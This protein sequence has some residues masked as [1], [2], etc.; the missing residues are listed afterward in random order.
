[1]VRYTYDTIVATGIFTHACT[2][3]RKRITTDQTWVKCKIYFT[4]ADR[5]RTKNLTSEEATYTTNQVETMVRDQLEQ[6]VAS[7]EAFQANKLPR[8]Q[9]LQWYLRR[10]LQII[11]QLTTYETSFKNYL[12]TTGTGMIIVIIATITTT[13]TTATTA[14][15]MIMATTTVTM[16]SYQLSK[17]MTRMAKSRFLLLHPWRHQKSSPS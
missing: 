9:Q 14:T 5:D 11:S 10:T 6:L 16:A 13:A 7:A 3:W 2:K 15:T 8:L 17:D 1:M 12:P 4:E